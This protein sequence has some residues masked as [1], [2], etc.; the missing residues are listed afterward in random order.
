MEKAIETQLPIVPEALFNSFSDQHENECLQGTRVDLL[1]QIKEWALSPQDSPEGKCI[2]WL[3]GMAGTGKST[4]SR[5]LARHFDTTKVL[6]AS[7]FFKRGEGDRGNAAKLISSIAR[8]LAVSVS[9]LLPYIEQEVRD[10]PGIAMKRMN[11]QF[12][13][14]IIQPLLNLSS[15]KP[16]SASQIVVIVIDALDECE[17]DDDI[18]LILHLLPQVQ[19]SSLLHLRVFITSRPELEIRLE[20]S[21]FSNH[22]DFILHKIAKEVISHDLSLFLNHRITEIRIERS[23]PGNWPGDSTIAQLVLLSS[24][25]FIFAATICRMFEDRFFDP[26]EILAEI[27][28]SSDNISKLDRTY[29]P[30]LKRQFRNSENKKH[31]D[32][33]VKEF[34]EVVGAIVILENPLSITSL[35]KLLD[36]TEST[37]Q[38]RLDLLHSVLSVPDSI[39]LPVRLFHLSFRD[40]LL[41]PETR[42]KTPLWIDP[43]RAHHDITIK[44]LSLCQK[45]L[46]KNIS[47]LSSPAKSCTGFDT[48]KY[49]PPQEMHY[50][51]RYWVYHLAQ[52]I[53]T[54]E[55]TEADAKDIIE[56]AISF[57]HTHFLHWVEA[58]ILMGLMSEVIVDIECLLAIAAVGFIYIPHFRRDCTKLQESE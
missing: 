54:F 33:V 2:F 46:R 34:Q 20:F 4:I 42:D 37:I 32:Q 45:G 6:G 17:R 38:G 27:L 21:K 9:G 22:K 19:K 58:M 35:S 10:D 47:Q 50:A 30:V 51:C 25:L 8:Q 5:T 13:K 7:F 39:N 12:N 11:E 49:N 1:R 18:R 53:E 43:K 31:R 3:N 40:F 56:N 36:I 28:L 57:L 26:V 52:S 24:P 15:E 44:C 16:N 14:L 55:D 23:I 48:P 41:D 29:L